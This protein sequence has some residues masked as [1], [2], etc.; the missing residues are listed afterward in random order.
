[1]KGP[2][3]TPTAKH[4]FNVNPDCVKLSKAKASEFHHLTAKLLYLCKHAWPD[5]QTAVSF[6][7]TRVHEPDE[8][9]YKKLSQCLQY[10]CD[11]IN[12]PLT[13]EINDSGIL[14]WWVDASFIVHLD[15][16]SHTGA[17]ISLG[18]G[19]PFSLSFR[20]CINTQSLTEAKLVRVNDAMYLIIWIWLFLKAQGFKVI[21][22][23]VHQD[24]QSTMLLECNRKTLSSKKTCHIEIQYLLRY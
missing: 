8:D 17:T 16:K 7:T 21:D 23:I 20:Q 15:M 24:N 5:L 6:L 2:S 22:N 1:M 10:L 3:M 9:D 18:G 4:L 13:L 12:I 14:Y 19:C 11:N